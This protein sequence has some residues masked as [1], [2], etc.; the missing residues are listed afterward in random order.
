[1]YIAMNRFRVAKGSEAAF[2]QV[3]LSRDT[4]L[5]K[6]PGFVEFH[7]LRGPELE[8]PHALRLP[9]RVGEPR[10]VRGLDQVGGVSRGASPGGRQQAALSRPSPVRRL[11][12]GADGGARCEVARRRAQPR[13]ILSISAISS[14][15]SFQAIAF[16]FSSTCS[17][18]VAPAI[19]LDTCGRAA[20]QEKASSSIEWPRALAKA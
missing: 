16:T 2:E 12:G 4:H 14:A 10:R 13:V 5:D 3:W 6:V 8:D 11:R 7:L 19:T 9:H 18:R 1:M 15:L 17:T 20:S